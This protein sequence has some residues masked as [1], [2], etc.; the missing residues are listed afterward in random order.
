MNLHILG[1]SGGIGGDLRTTSLLIDH[2]ILIDAGTGVGNLA[3]TE[4]KQVRHV[5]LT[6]SHL[7]HIASLPLLVDSIFEH[8][9]HH[10][11]T[12]ITVYAL[13]ST[14]KAL[15][16]HIFNWVIWPDFSGLPDR[17][18][19]VMVFREMTPGEVVSVDGRH[20]EMIP[21]NHAVPSVGYYLRSDNGKSLAFSGDTTTNDTFWDGLNMRQ[22]LDVLIIEVAF[23]NSEM[24]LSKAAYHYCPSLLAEDLKKLQHQP[25]I[26]ISHHKPGVEKVIEQE[27]AQDIPHRQLICLKG[28]ESFTL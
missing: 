6:H 10:A 4:M 19:P 21:V 13:P 11:G 8:L 3:L 2:D 16:D 12:P 24:A 18:H 9:N 26:Y 1:C 17:N 15:K 14:I 23:P 27:L 20:V 5:F 28:D 7:D 22:T 25:K